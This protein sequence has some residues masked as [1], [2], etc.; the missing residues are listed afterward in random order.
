M[1]V[2]VFSDSHGKLALAH[3]IIQKENCD[4]ILHMGDS[5]EDMLELKSCYDIPVVGVVGNVDYVTEGPEQV[6]MVIGGY[7][8]FLCHGHRYRVNQNLNHL[9]EK[10]K[11]MDADIILYGHTHT[12]Y[13]NKNLPVIM[14]P[15]SISRPRVV[16]H[17]SYGILEL[18]KDSIKGRIIYVK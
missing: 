15:G 8:V 17:P 16:T 2:L 4:M 1:K 12:P 7:K 6:S 10:G 14:N 5:F 3:D 9:I 13:Y 11:T 18:E